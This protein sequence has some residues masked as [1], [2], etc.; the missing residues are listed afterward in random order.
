[1]EDV[2][3]TNMDFKSYVLS[4]AQDA[5]GEVYVLTSNNTGPASGPAGGVDS[6]YK[7]VP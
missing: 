3:I 2:K 1:M 7:I 6:I 5:D 4:Y